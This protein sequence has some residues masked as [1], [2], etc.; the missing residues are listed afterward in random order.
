MAA[1]TRDLTR[2]G[3]RTTAAELR[4][5][6][7]P[8]ESPGERFRAEILRTIDGLRKKGLDHAEAI[9][10]LFPRTVLPDSTYEDLVTAVVAGAHVLFF[11]PSGAGK[12]SLAK[13][14]WGLFPKGVWVVD[15]CPVLDHPLSLVDPRAAARFPPCPICERR[16]APDGDPTKFDPATT[17]PA[18]VPAEFVLLREGFGFARLQGSS[19]VFPDHLTVTS[20]SASSRRSGIP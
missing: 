5:A 11:G 2:P 7:A 9:R 17:D 19:E 10:A 4:A 18:S 14:L 8:V 15:G 6:H 3:T 12:T 20:T 1:P 13:D 16:F